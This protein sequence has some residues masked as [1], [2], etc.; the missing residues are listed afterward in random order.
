MRASNALGGSESG[1][2]TGRREREAVSDQLVALPVGDDANSGVGARLAAYLVDVGAAWA[3]ATP[4]ERNTLA[5]QLFRSVVITNR[6]AVARL[7]RPD[8]RPFF[9]VVAVN[10]D[11]ELCCGGSDWDCYRHRVMRLL[12]LVPSALPP[13][14]LVA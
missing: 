13:S 9:S 5:R 11:E 3:V 4:E 2:P 12:G 6:T 14:R 10:N 7:P 1:P 8:L